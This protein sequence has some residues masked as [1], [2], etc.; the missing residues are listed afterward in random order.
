MLS[1]LT[2]ENFKS[3]K[4]QT[5]TLKPLTILTG[6]NSTGKSSIIQSVLLLS[7]CYSNTNQ[8]LLVSVVSAI[9]DFR[10]IRNKYENA[11]SL[12]IK[13]DDFELY[14]DNE[15]LK[16]NNETKGL[17]GLDYESN[18]FYLS[19]NRMGQEEIAKL[20]NEQKIGLNGEYIFGYFENNK[21]KLLE[22]SLI[23][24]VT[25]GHTLKAQLNE[26][27]QYILD[28]PISI[29]TEKITTSNVKISFNSDGIDFINPFNLGAGNSYLAKI[30][31]ITL[32][33]FRM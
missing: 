6:L 11:Q 3:I 5:F 22:Q 16:V 7:K 32:M 24:F 13:A 31:I 25:T 27:L 4:S 20:S 21:D 9:S 2:I 23:K 1:K 14:F 18:L 10:E 29:Q 30:L 26:W 28:L 8:D 33:C 19:A 15:A 12:T 17:N